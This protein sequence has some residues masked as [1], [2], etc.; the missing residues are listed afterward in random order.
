VLI[1]LAGILVLGY[2]AIVV[3]LFFYQR[4][5]LYFPDP[6]RPQLGD[7]AALGVREVQIVTADGLSLLGWYRPPEEGRPVIL[8]FHGNGGHIGYRAERVRRFAEGGFGLLTPEYRGYGGNPG[9]P[10]E[11]GLFADGTAALEFLSSERIDPR[12]LVLYGESL[13]SGIAV[14]LAAQH[15]V[16][17]VILEA[18]YTSIA[19]V[20]QYHYPFVPVALLLRDHFNS[21]SRIGRVKAPVLIVHGGRDPVVPARFSKALYAAAPEPKEIWFAADAGHEDLAG[22]GALDAAFDF[23]ARR[24]GFQPG[25]PR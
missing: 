8:Y 16:A 6:R 23:I 12:R 20:A 4:Q 3:A 7:L 1:W 18:P 9:S 24:A 2:V 5:L 13:G 19:A 22:Y 10:S 21:L 14:Y 25:Q 17:A 11:A 15:E